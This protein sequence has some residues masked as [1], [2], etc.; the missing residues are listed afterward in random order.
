MSNQRV[1][2]MLCLVSVTS[3][4]FETRQLLDLPDPYTTTVFHLVF[5]SDYLFPL[6]MF[7]HPSAVGVLI[8]ESSNIDVCVH[9]TGAKPSYSSLAT[10]GSSSTRPLSDRFSESLLA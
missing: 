5:W 1:G 3:T 8:W 4:Q 7:F 2:M 10:V 9:S 6:I